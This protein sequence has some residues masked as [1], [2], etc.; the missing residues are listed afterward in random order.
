MADKV[1]VKIDMQSLTFREQIDFE[2]FTGVS[3]PSLSADM[4]LTTKMVVALIWLT[5][6]R[7]NPAFTVDDA[8][9]LTYE[10]VELESDPTP[11]EPVEL[12]PLRDKPA[13][14]KA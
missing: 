12:Q 11:A 4:Q 13:S 10:D 9:A 8:M 14:R 1:S 5:E 2:E 6:R 3:I 7:R